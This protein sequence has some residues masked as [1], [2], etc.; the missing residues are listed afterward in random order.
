MHALAIKH[1]T[2]ALQDPHYKIEHAAGQCHLLHQLSWWIPSLKQGS[3]TYAKKEVAA[4]P[5]EVVFITV[6]QAAQSTC[7]IDTST[8]ARKTTRTSCGYPTVLAAV[9]KSLRSSTAWNWGQWLLKLSPQGSF[10]RHVNWWKWDMPSDNVFDAHVAHLKYSSTQSC[11]YGAYFMS[12]IADCVD[13]QLCNT[14]FLEVAA[15]GLLRPRYFSTKRVNYGIRSSE[16][17]AQFAWQIVAASSCS[18]R[19]QSQH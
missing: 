8:N 14:E 10:M 2:F 12:G 3:T 11:R 13:G 15:F 7:R 5:G 9:K 4:S 18:R 1:D 6:P 16:M 19:P 17:P